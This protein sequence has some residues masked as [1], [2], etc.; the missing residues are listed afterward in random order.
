MA[1]AA[2]SRVLICIGLSILSLVSYWAVAENQFVSFDDPQYVTENYH[3]Q[4]GLNRETAVWAFTTSRASNWHPLTWLSLMLD[5]DLYGRNAGGYHWTN[6][7]LHLLGGLF[8][9]LALSRM[10]TSLWRSGLVAALFLVHPLHVESVAW[11][12]ERNDVLS[13]L[14]WMLGTWG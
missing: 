6:V 7:I 1:D 10:T 2:R 5:R 4:K 12:E 3:V 11:I 14:F 13:G 8:L 9:F